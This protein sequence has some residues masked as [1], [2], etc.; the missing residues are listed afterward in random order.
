MRQSAPVNPLNAAAAFFAAA[1]PDR[2]PIFAV[3]KFALCRGQCGN[4][5]LCDGVDLVALNA[6]KL[7]LAKFSALGRYSSKPR[8]RFPPTSTN[9]RPISNQ[10]SR[11]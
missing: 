1:L 2:L 9:F 6:M 8:S 11:G 10:D 5:N 4:V 3:V 7:I